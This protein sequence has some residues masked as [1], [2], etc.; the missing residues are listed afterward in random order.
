MPIGDTTIV[1]ECYCRKI[2]Q[3]IAY[4]TLGPTWEPVV[5]YKG[6]SYLV[7]K[8]YRLTQKQL[9]KYIQHCNDVGIV[10][11]DPVSGDTSK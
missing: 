7:E 9:E 8:N 4:T 5:N 6:N 11:V 10:W 3:R 1:L 2:Q